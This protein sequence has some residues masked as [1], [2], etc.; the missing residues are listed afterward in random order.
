MLK[1]RVVVAFAAMVFLL[2]LWRPV[3]AVPLAGS[4]VAGQAVISQDGKE[5]LVS[6][7][8][9]R[10]VI[11]W[12]DFSLKADEQL[13]FIV[14]SPT[15][16]T[17]NRFLGASPLIS[18]TILSNGGVYLVHPNGMVFD[19]NARV[20]ANRVEISTAAMAN[21]DFM[22]R[23]TQDWVARQGSLKLDG[24]IEAPAIRATAGSL[25]IGGTLRAER[26][27]IELVAGTRLATSEAA[28]IAADGGSRGDGGTIRLWSDRFTDFRGTVTA[29]GGREFGSGGKVEISAAGVLDFQGSV[30][31]DAPHG[32]LGSLLL[33][34]SDIEIVATRPEG[35]I[36]I[37]AS[38]QR[39][40]AIASDQTSYLVV[41]KLVASLQR[42]DVTV[43]A[44]T[45]SEG[46]AAG[47]NR[48]TVSSAV[49]WGGTGNLTLNAGK[50]GIVIDA[51]ISS[52]NS[53]KRS[54][55]LKSIGSISSS[56]AGVLSINKL[57]ATSGLGGIFLGAANRMSTIG[58]ISARAG[59][60]ILLRNQQGLALA[61][62]VTLSAGTGSV[63]LLLPGYDL[64]LLGSVTV[65]AGLLR[66]D[67]GDHRIKGKQSLTATGS[68]VYF[69]GAATGHQGTLNLG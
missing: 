38:N 67:L 7:A 34:P 41:S 18:G 14:P 40:N 29:M 57:T 56:S 6:Q 46:D 10:A 8:S 4:V 30:A 63:A 47:S 35:E 39:F 32:G 68:T 65:E 59:G 21:F 22:N 9:D 62:G 13:R 15:S 19:L 54:L 45:A 16:A 58:A 44:T 1:L 66:L 31:T 2:P 61:S 33:D 36:E 51:E 5:T 69:T 3:G 20:M 26:G 53:T 24:V 11:E 23:E 52:T 55:T 12:R 43:D 48:I 27:Q 28:V 50:G 25:D 42:N 64:T 49:R 37:T 60:S 17:L